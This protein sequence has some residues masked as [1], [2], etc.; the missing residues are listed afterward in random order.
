MSGPPSHPQLH[1][2]SLSQLMTIFKSPQNRKLSN[3]TRKKLSKKTKRIGAVLG[4]GKCYIRE[5][6]LAVSR[7]TK[8]TRFLYSNSDDV[9]DKAI[10]KITQVFRLKE[11]RKA[12]KNRTAV[13]RMPEFCTLKQRDALPH[14]ILEEPRV[15]VG[16]V[17]CGK[18]ASQLFVTEM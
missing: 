5:V 10:R 13:G 3:T 7:E 6:F 14:P 17:G 1:L 9:V 8:Q 12:V 2:N 15:K 18:G 11:F 16:K 4:L